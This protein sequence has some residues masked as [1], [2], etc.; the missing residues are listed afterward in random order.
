MPSIQ[1]IQ[2]VS[3]EIVNEQLI[4][5]IEALLSV[6]KSLV[7]CEISITDKRVNSFSDTINHI[8][9]DLVNQNSNTDLLKRKC[10]IEKRKEF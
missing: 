3:T 5:K 9:K 1:S 2:N 4:W 7:N 6:L 10:R 8:L